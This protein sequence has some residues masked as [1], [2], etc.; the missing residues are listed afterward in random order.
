MLANLAL[1]R[2]IVAALAISALYTLMVFTVDPVT[3]IIFLNGVFVGSMVAIT[4]AYHRLLWFSLIGRGEY[5]RL[6]QMALG[7]AVGWA[8]IGISAFNS[9]YLRSLGVDIPSTPLTALTRFLSIV[10]AVMQVT[11]PDFGYGLFYGRDRRVTWIALAAGLG[12]AAVTV[13]LQWNSLNF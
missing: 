8:A 11:A 13:A 2:V 10:A 9:I 4:V 1:S 3:L 12:F 5:N 6:R 7:I